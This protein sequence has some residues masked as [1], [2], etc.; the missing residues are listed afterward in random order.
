[1][2]NRSIYAKPARCAA[3]AVLAAGLVIGVAGAAQGESNTGAT[4]MTSATNA[5]VLSTGWVKRSSWFTYTSCA[6]EGQRW[7]TSGNAVA[8]YC[9]GVAQPW[10]HWDLYTRSA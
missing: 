7:I 6:A 1:M 3:T 8:Y 2:L 10:F 5:S 4:A 9:S